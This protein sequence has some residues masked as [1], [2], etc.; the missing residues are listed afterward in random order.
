MALSFRALGSV[1]PFF[2]CLLHE[3]QCGSQSVKKYVLTRPIAICLALS[4]MIHIGVSEEW[5][6]EFGIEHKNTGV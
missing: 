2:G 4:P 1:I 3:E 5:C 6:I